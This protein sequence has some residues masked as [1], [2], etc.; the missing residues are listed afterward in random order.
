MVRSFKWCS[1]GIYPGPSPVPVIVNDLPDWK[2]SSIKLYA[3][4]TKVRRVIE[5]KEDKETLQS[6]LDKLIEW[7]G[8]WLL[9]F[10]Q[11]KGK[12]MFTGGHKE[13]I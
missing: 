1:S 7:S 2:K 12:L 3:D 11:E 8:K 6:D 9:K 13:G 5:D 4:D 10:N